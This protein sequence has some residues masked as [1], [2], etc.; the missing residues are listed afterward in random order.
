MQ[1][2]ISILSLIAA[3][4]LFKIEF[5]VETKKILKQLNLSNK[6]LAELKAVALTIPNED[7]LINTL[8][9]QEAKDSSAVEN[10]VTTHDD[11]YNKKIDM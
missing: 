4:N 11:L 6:K 8:I 7:I 2:N 3:L 9:L 1:K 5:D 10:I